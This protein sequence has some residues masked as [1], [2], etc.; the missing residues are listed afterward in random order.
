MVTFCLSSGSVEWLTAG[1]GE[2]QA[3]IY[4]INQMAWCLNML[5]MGG[6]PGLEDVKSDKLYLFPLQLLVGQKKDGHAHS[7]LNNA[8]AA[9]SGE[10]RLYCLLQT[11]NATGGHHCCPCTIIAPCCTWTN[12][13]QVLQ[14]PLLLVFD[15]YSSRMP[16]TSLARP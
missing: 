6:M 4:H 14:V 5:P 8:R 16:Y 7:A 11:G 1:W 2:M 10:F 15:S 9:R 3:E 13:V 12:L